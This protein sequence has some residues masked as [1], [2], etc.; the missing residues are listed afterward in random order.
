MADHQ[1]SSCL[2][3]SSYIFL[4]MTFPLVYSYSSSVSDG[5]SSEAFCSFSLAYKETAFSVCVTFAKW[6]N[7]SCHEHDT[8]QQSSGRPLALGRYDLHK[9]H[10]CSWYPGHDAYAASRGWA[11]HPSP[12][13]GFVG[14]KWSHSLHPHFFSLWLPLRILTLTCPGLLAVYIFMSELLLF[15]EN[16]HVFIDPGFQKSNIFVSLSW[17]FT[18]CGFIYLFFSSP[19]LTFLPVFNFI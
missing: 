10:N 17:R 6:T 13:A 1:S 9:S 14:C 16:L 18:L 15:P 11:C 8:I 19:N 4:F 2:F 3:R 7:T 5:H 12:E